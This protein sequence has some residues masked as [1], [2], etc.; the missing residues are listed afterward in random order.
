VRRRRSRVGI[1]ETGSASRLLSLIDPFEQK[2]DTHERCAALMEAV[3]GLCGGTGCAVAGWDPLLEFSD[4]LIAQGQWEGIDVSTVLTARGRDRALF[5]AAGTTGYRLVESSRAGCRI[6]RCARE[7]A[8]AFALPLAWGGRT[9]GALAVTYNDLVAVT[10]AHCEAA[11]LIARQLS[12]CLAYDKLRGEHVEQV[13][14]IARM[15][16]DIERLCSLLRGRRGE[17]AG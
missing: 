11:R 6:E 16:T 7:E 12:L 1:A 5:L 4:V 8:T 15:S 13:H 10:D 2:V 17:G 3:A 14:R 9:L